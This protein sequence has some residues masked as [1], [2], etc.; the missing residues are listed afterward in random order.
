MPHPCEM[1]YRRPRRLRVRAP[2]GW[3]S[4]LVA[5]RSAA[6]GGL[7]RAARQPRHWRQTARRGSPQRHRGDRRGPGRPAA[8]AAWRLVGEHCGQGTYVAAPSCR[9]C[10]ARRH[11]VA[12]H[13][14]GVSAATRRVPVGTPGILSGEMGQRGLRR[15][16]RRRSGA[17]RTATRPA[18]GRAAPA[19]PSRR[20]GPRD[21]AFPAPSSFVLEAAWRSLGPLLGRI[22]LP[23]VAGVGDEHGEEGHQ[24]E[25]HQEEEHTE[26]LVSA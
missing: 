12:T 11:G 19:A 3:R 15:P 4:C 13:S 1:R 8:L 23:Q 7:R 26:S 21:R 6:A 16:R 22:L 17:G 2:A 9:A 14:P 24:E 10:Q 5:R 20:A 25:G 18:S